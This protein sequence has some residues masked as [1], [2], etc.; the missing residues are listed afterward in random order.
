MS[1]AEDH[2]KHVYA[3]GARDVRCLTAPI[4]RLDLDPDAYNE[5]A[6]H[7]DRFDAR[8]LALAFVDCHLQDGEEEVSLVHQ[9]GPYSDGRQVSTTIRRDDGFVT[10]VHH[11]DPDGTPDLGSAQG[12][13]PCRTLV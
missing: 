6:C 13:S 11:P 9:H 5:I 12:N 4:Q 10:L 1:V 7:L 8:L 3:L 2:K